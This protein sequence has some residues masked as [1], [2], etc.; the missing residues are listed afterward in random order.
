M[1][2][3]RRWLQ[4]V[5]AVAAAGWAA[6]GLVLGL[7][8]VLPTPNLYMFWPNLILWLTA[9]LAQELS[10]WL[11]AF[12]LVGLALALLA[13][14]AGARRSSLVAAVFAVTTVVLSLVPVV[15]GFR[16]AAQEDVPLSL[17]QYFSYPSVGSPETTTYARPEG[18]ELKLD[19][20]RPPEGGGTA[21]P[22][23][24]PA[25]VLVHGGGGIMGSRNEEA[26][27]SQWLAEQGY[28][29][30][31]IDYRLGPDS[32]LAATADVKCAVGW[33]KHNADR[34]GLDPDRIALMGR[35]SG[36]HRALLAA[37]TKGDPRLPPSCDAPDT[38]V[39]AVAAFYSPT[40]FIRLDE[41]QWPWWRPDL[42]GWIDGA[43]GG[44]EESGPQRR[45]TSPIFHVN[46]GDPPTFL[47]HG[48]Q[49][50]FVPL[51]QSRLLAD[52]LEQEG[53]PQRLLVL[54]GARHGFDS[55][56][57]GWNQQI[58]RH[59]LGVFLELRG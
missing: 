4:G 36:G 17:S 22:R 15:Q 42:T 1:T 37:Y 34:Y 58:V 19:I 8:S 35:S 24:R 47:A 3:G 28:V 30:F 48:D 12:A 11:A 46:P 2:A 38:G 20:R 21:G 50:Q 44:N 41:M 32:S 45:L 27:W 29:A 40:D 59:E 39:T 23:G 16:T 5:L 49:D 14:R 31:A 13:R 51:E 56:W 25:V 55:A 33:V 10:L 9:M 6:I 18:Q 7:L 54:P 53:V 52:R 57:G 43:T 26:L